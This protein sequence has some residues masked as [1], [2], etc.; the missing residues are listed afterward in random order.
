MR[1]VNLDYFR[2]LSVKSPNEEIFK[3]IM[4][5]SAQEAY[6]KWRSDVKA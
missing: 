2:V 3:F 5:T 6:K 1:C 4:V